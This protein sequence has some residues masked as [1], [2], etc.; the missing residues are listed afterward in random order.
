MR[1]HT[2]RLALIAFFAALLCSPSHATQIISFGGNLTLTS[3]T[4]FNMQVNG[5]VRGTNYDSLAVSGQASLAGTLNFLVSNTFSPFVGEEFLA[6]SYGSYS[7]AF[8]TIAPSGLASNLFLTADYRTNG[9]YLTVGTNALPPAVT[10]EP[11]SL[12]LL[13]TGFLG[14]VGAARKRFA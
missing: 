2:F 5:P 1:P 11:S 12:L 8:G 6:V 13:G 7:G 10:P 4:V 14:V 3:S 9:L